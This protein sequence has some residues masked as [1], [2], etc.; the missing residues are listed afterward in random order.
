M[1]KV[2][3]TLAAFV[4]IGS[5]SFAQ[6]IADFE[7]GMNDFFDNGW[8]T[9]FKS[10]N[11]IAD[12]T[13]QSTGVLEIVFDGKGEAGGLKANL[14]KDEVDALGAQIITYYVYL[15]AD[16]PDGL[17][18]ACWGQDKGTWSWTT[19][20]YTSANIPKGVW[21]PL[22]FYIEQYRIDP[23]V[24]FDAVANKIGKMGLDIANWNVA[25]KSWTGSILVDNVTLVGAEPKSF[26]KFETGLDDFKS[27][28]GSLGTISQIA[29]PSAQSAGVLSV[30]YG[31]GGAFG[32]EKT[33]DVKA[34]DLMVYWV[35]LPASVPNEMYLKV[36]AQDNVNWSWNDNYIVASSI[37]KEVWYPI[38]FDLEA[39][40]AKS[41]GGTFNH[42]TMSLGK[43][44][45]EV[46]GATW[47]GAILVDNVSFINSETGDKWVICN[48][49]AALAGT[50]GFSIPNWAPAGIT[51]AH[52]EDNG[53]G[54][55]QL[56]V[57]YSKG[58]KLA[59]S[60]GEISLNYAEKDTIIDEITID[61]FLP[62]DFPVGN[63]LDL[64]F[65]PTNT[66][67]WIA[68]NYTIA[69]DGNVQPGKWTT[70]SWNVAE[71]RSRITD[72][73]ALG[74]FFVEF[75]VTG[76]T[77]YTG[78]VLFDNLT[79]VGIPEP[80][81]TLAS[82]DLVA[83]ADTAS[84]YAGL[85]H[86]V[87]FDWVDN[88]LGTEKYNIYRSENPI[89]DLADPNVVK[90][91]PDV[92]HGLQAYAHRPWSNTSV[93]KQYYFAITAID[94]GVETGLTDGNKV[95]PVTI[96]TSETPKIKYVGDFA[97]AFVLDGL[98]NEFEQYKAA[99]QFIPE[100]A[101][102]DAGA[103]WD[104]N[105]TDCMFKCVLLMDDN[106]LYISADVTDD[107][108]NTDTQYQTWQGDALEF[109]IGYYDVRTLK[110]WHTKNFSKANGDWRIGFNT[111]NQITLDGSTV[112]DVPG[113]ES[114][115]F[116]KFTGDG[117]IIEAKLCLDSLALGGN[118]D[119]TNG[120]LMPL[121]IDCNDIDP[122]KGDVGRS[123]ILQLG[124]VPTGGRVDMDQDWTR[125]HAWALMEVVD[126]PTAVGNEVSNLP[127][128]FKLHNNYPNPFNPATRIKFDLPKESFVTLKVYDITG[129]EVASLINSNRKA[130]YHE[131][132]FDA[133]NLASGIYMYRLIANDFSYTKKMMLIK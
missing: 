133:S 66:W 58:E 103:G 40:T 99:Y 107:D 12:P 3:L 95:G 36:F 27:L 55:L 14:E 33:T 34:Y 70:L 32:F 97:N 26:A 82:P 119:V 125:P 59:V 65:Q 72:K 91:C 28:W 42:H 132:T 120:L 94:G 39:A 122:S 73:T 106:Y 60:K 83:A 131:V 21:Y 102:G 64:V 16:C 104:E 93:E 112:T 100:G 113:V 61:V 43:A 90:I 78:N 85:Q 9:A 41:S 52:G 116:T 7:T 13:G 17:D 121:R 109:Y 118:I 81:G 114:T 5:F 2:L 29:D 75:K 74:Y 108:V 44:G 84:N 88:T 124:G 127:K 10:V 96:Q 92:P 57:D 126:G 101:G 50:Q 71:F 8:G 38:Y 47:T 49:N 35:W 22:N 15:P 79:L 25:D 129:R 19:Q 48:F 51:L 54:V 20:S 117:Y 31:T 18:I 53:N 23:N 4:L 80:E 115:I 37:P 110:E 6:V 86:F 130:G 62:S 30:D 123:M 56:G 1:K 11:Q 45:I 24:N 111:L 67:D 69:A 128:E 63:S 98:D 77:T 76:N 46:G 89:T 105:S 87:R 68:K